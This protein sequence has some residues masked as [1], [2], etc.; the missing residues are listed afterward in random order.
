VDEVERD[1]LERA[2]RAVRDAV[3]GDREPSDRV[4]FR[5]RAIVRHRRMLAVGSI[6]TA[7]I[8]TSIGIGLAVRGGTGLGVHTI[9]PVGSGPRPTG[10]ASLTTVSTTSPA[11]QVLPSSQRL[12]QIVFVDA[13]HGWRAAPVVGGKSIDV[14]SD[15]GRTWTVQ[16]RV[17]ADNHDT[18]TVEGIV[19][20][21]RL[22]AFALAYS[23]NTPEGAALPTF[24][25]RT[26]DGSHWARVATRG[27]AAPLFTIVFADPTHGWGMT[28]SGGLVTTSDGG[29]RWRAMSQPANP[30]AGAALCLA[31][32][33]SGWAATGNAVYRSDNDGASWMRQFTMAYGGDPELVCRGSHVAFAAFDHGAGQSSGGFVRSDDGGVHWRALTED[34]RSGASP[35]TA[36]GFPETQARGIPTA[37]AADGTLVFITACEVCPLAL[38]WVVVA[39]PLDRFVVG[40]FD[41]TSSGH[42]E[43]VDATAPDSSRIYAEVRRLDPN[44]STGGTVSLYASSDGGRTWQWRSRE[45]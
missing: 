4:R 20:I 10:K 8:A 18:N 7:M 22:H 33:G 42:F 29:V 13:R 27:L 16:H 34:L 31:A 19:A 45:G 2:G 35:A 11:E 21:D 12:P 44:S 17:P 37:M 6:A 24:L 39:S 14:T 28:V 30:G 40:H 15:G 26:T 25:L 1:E 23:G 32:P 41:D 36:P 43:V 3:A 5:A 38:H 9:A